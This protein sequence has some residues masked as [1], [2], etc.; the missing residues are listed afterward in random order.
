MTLSGG[1]HGT[2]QCS[3]VCAYTPIMSRF[4][5]ILAEDSLCLRVGGG[6]KRKNSENE[7]F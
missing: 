1:G 7:L 3:T 5:E 6:G 4:F 2:V